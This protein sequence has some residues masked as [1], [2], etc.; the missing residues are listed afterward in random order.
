MLID[1]HLFFQHLVV[2]PSDHAGGLVL[3]QL[4]CVCVCV[5]V[6]VYVHMGW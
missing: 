1:T 2:F 6:C 5:F 3:H 4:V